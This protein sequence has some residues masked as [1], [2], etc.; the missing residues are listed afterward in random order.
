MHYITYSFA[1]G[2]DFINISNP[3]NITLRT[4]ISPPIKITIINDKTFEL[5]EMFSINLSLPDHEALPPGVSLNQT[6]AQV[7]I[8]DNDGEPFYACVLIKTLLYHSSLH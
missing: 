3:V 8:L 7:I 4:S 6:S 5:T 2:E 1:A